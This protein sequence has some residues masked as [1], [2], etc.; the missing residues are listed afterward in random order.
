MKPCSSKPCNQCPFRRKSLPGYLGTASTSQFISSTMMDEPMPC[1]QT[2]DY[3]DPNWKD[4]LRV[5]GSA[6]YC[7]GAAVFFANICKE[8]RDPFREVLPADHIAVLA[9]PLEFIQHHIAG[10]ERVL[11]PDPDAHALLEGRAFFINEHILLSSVEKPK[12][13]KPKRSKRSKR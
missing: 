4:Q 2:V 7:A 6:H 5:E 8:T 12:R 13:A 9:S 3:E 10:N 11:G 1:H